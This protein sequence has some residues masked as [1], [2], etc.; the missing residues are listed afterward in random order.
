M[1]VIQ[2]LIKDFPIIPAA[3]LDSTK[4][5]VKSIE[6]PIKELRHHYYLAKYGSDPYDGEFEYLKFITKG[7]DWRMAGAGIGADKESRRNVSNEL[8]KAFARWFMSKYLGHNYFC[9]FDVAMKRS[10]TEAHKWSR[11]EPGDLPDY[12]CG[13]DEKDVNLLEAKGRYES[14]AF[15]N[16]GFKKFREQ[17]ARA[18]LCDA[19]GQELAVKGFISVARWAT[20]ETPKTK[21]TL[22]V[23][24]PW[25]EGRQ[26]GEYP[27][28]AGRSMVLGH[29]VSA[30][31]RLQLP[32]LADSLRFSHALPAQGS[33]ERRA[34]WACR[35]GPL[36]GKEFVG[37]IIPGSRH[38]YGWSDYYHNW[39]H[40]TDV[41]LPPFE[42][43]GLERS[44]FEGLIR[45]ARASRMD[46]PAIEPVEVP[47]ALGS[48]SLLRDGSVLGP[49]SYFKRIDVMEY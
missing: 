9:D 2:L 7:P 3:L 44:T 24:D 38:A 43:F 15:A 45:A 28:S 46:L 17:I 1:R 10:A 30:L 5:A 27:R 8:G 26:D 41:L 25:T 20:E 13:R 6:V 22:L 16:A 4:N 42:F 35:T 39:F 14:V 12:V 31:D 47:E 40:E 34:I 36:Q 11:R 19:S 29:Y 33:G 21:S 18:R 49:A 23:E 48:I 37:G 32:V